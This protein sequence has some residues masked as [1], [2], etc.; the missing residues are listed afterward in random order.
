MLE[1]I[2]HHYSLSLKAGCVIPLEQVFGDANSS[3]S[4]VTIERLVS[5]LS[6]SK[7]LAQQII[8][9]YSKMLSWAI[10]ILIDIL[11]PSAFFLAGNIE[12]LLPFMLPGITREVAASSV[13][14]KVKSRSICAGHAHELTSRGSGKMVLD[15]WLE[16]IN[17]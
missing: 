14:M 3:E 17:L 5:D 1:T 8:D 2:V 15:R 16:R 9:F 11:D 10:S 12:P 4:R 6:S 7:P 13:L